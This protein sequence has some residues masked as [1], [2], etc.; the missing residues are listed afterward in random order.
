VAI[1][2]RPNRYVLLFLLGPGS[3]SAVTGNTSKDE[4]SKWRSHRDF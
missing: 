2:R 3:V 1:D 4:S